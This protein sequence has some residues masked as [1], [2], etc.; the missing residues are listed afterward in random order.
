VTAFP[1][2][3][4]LELKKQQHEIGV[5]YNVAVFVLNFIKF[6]QFT[7]KPETQMNML[8]PVILPT[9]LI[10]VGNRWLFILKIKSVR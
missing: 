9:L 4:P 2:L 6:K 10:I 1:K 8:R 3:S 5:D 7:R